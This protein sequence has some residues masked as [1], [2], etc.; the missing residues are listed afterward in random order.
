MIA[1][2][3]AKVKGS[4]ESLYRMM[5]TGRFKLVAEEDHVEARNVAK[6]HGQT[7]NDIRRFGI[8]KNIGSC[9]RVV[10]DDVHL[11]PNVDQ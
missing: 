9:E 10:H 11:I 7:S 6:N 4:N 3:L 2:S 1:D 5:Q 8:N